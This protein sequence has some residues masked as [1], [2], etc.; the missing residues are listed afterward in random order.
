[1]IWIILVITSRENADISANGIRLR[2][3][4]PFRTAM[5]IQVL[6]HT[7]DIHT[8]ITSCHILGTMPKNTVKAWADT[9]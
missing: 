6:F 1:M 5:I 4:F 9:L 7:T 8:L 2:E 3:I